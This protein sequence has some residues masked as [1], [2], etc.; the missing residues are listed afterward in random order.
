MTRSPTLRLRALQA[1]A[2]AF[3]ATLGTLASAQDFPTSPTTW[4]R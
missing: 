3:C 1:C 2:F 4:R